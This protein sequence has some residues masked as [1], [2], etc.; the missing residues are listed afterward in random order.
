MSLP[1]RCCDGG[2]EETDADV[3]GGGG[4]GNKNGAVVVA[5]GAGA[6]GFAVVFINSVKSLMSE[7]M[8][9]SRDD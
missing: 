1:L 9:H 2:N 5:A 8:G 3:G 6:G 4:G 7:M